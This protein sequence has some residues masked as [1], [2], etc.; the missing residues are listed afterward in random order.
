[1]ITRRHFMKDSAMAAGAA[2]LHP[3]RLPSAR[4]AARSDKAVVVS[5]AADNVLRGETYNPLVVRKMFGG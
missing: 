5:V 1:M 2:L 4:D 3:N